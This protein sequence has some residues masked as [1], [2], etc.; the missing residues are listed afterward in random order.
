[1]DHAAI[2]TKTLDKVLD[3]ILER[4]NSHKFID[5]KMLD[6]FQNDFFTPTIQV[7]GTLGDLPARNG[8]FCFVQGIHSLLLHLTSKGFATAEKWCNICHG[9]RAQ[10]HMHDHVLRQTDQTITECTL[11]ERLPLGSAAR[12]DKQQV[13][14]LHNM[15][16]HFVLKELGMTGLSVLFKYGVQVEGCFDEFMHTCLLGV[17]MRVT[18]W[19]L[20]SCAVSLNSKGIANALSDLYPFTRKQGNLRNLGTDRQVGARNKLTAVVP[21]LFVYAKQFSDEACDCVRMSGYQFAPA[22]QVV[23]CTLLDVCSFN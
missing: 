19:T 14:C 8:M 6:A 18:D 13:F 12:L 3:K 1:L 10:K 4:M 2:Q 22:T 7:I 23:F 16:F 20:N 5:E 15:S 9:T 17:L 21:W 11:L